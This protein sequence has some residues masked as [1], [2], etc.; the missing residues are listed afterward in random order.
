MTNWIKPITL[1]GDTVR[2]TPLCSEDA[3]GLFNAA[4]P[5]TFRHFSRGPTP[6]TEAG[7][8]AF[9]EHLLGPA[10]TVPFCINDKRT[11]RRIG[12]STYLDI[13]DE[14][15]GLEIGW[16]WLTPEARGTR[17]N[18]EMKLLMMQHAFEE[19]GAIRVCLKTDLRNEHSQAAIEKLGATR[20]GVLR[21]AV[22]MGDG[23]R[24]SS[25]M[26]SILAD[27]WARVRDGLIR[28]LEM[29]A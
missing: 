22:I 6:W 28:R 27:E 19:L 25:V 12:I 4:T 20:E 18:P 23:Y 17:I 11:G 16:T 2:L 15:K 24:R 10:N 8:L 1:E 13:K 9:I 7:M 26:Y 3:A 29:Q 5:E 21:D 14:H